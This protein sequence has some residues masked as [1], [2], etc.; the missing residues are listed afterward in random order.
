MAHLD[1]DADFNNEDVPQVVDEKDIPEDV[2]EAL[3]VRQRG[4][5]GGDAQSVK[6]LVDEEEAEGSHR[7][8]EKKKKKK[9][10]KKKGNLRLK[11][12]AIRG[13][14]KGVHFSKKSEKSNTSGRKTAEEL[15]NERAG[16]KRDKYAWA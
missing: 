12:L 5:E 2:R 4:N 16:Q 7:H 1:L 10:R 14:G 3:R 13:A 11:G 9:G 6:A 8:H 15:L